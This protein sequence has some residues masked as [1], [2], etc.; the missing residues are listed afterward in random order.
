MMAL[1]KTNELL[2]L[3]GLVLLGF[4]GLGFLVTN[5]IC[6]SIL[7]EFATIAIIVFSGIYDGSALFL[8]MN[9]LENLGNSRT[10]N[11]K[12]DR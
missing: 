5:I 6:V 7:G 1:Y 2:L 11:F 9:K 4:A 3:P 12:S 8:A 10:L